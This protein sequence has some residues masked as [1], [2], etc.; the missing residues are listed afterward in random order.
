[1]R[2]YWDYESA[3]HREAGALAPEPLELPYGQQAPTSPFRSRDYATRWRA[4]EG[5]YRVV[6]A[7]CPPIRFI[8]RYGLGLRCPGD[9]HLRRLAMPLLDRII[10]PAQA[11]FGLMEVRGTPWPDSDSGFVASW[12]A[13]SEFAKIQTGVVVY[14]PREFCLYQGPIPNH[15]LLDNQPLDVMAGIEYAN[16]SRLIAIAGAPHGVARLNII[17]RLPSDSLK[18]A[19]GALFAW[20]FLALKTKVELLRLESAALAQ[21]ND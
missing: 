21:P 6:P 7:D 2:L 8:S 10:D 12:I 1:M 20:A 9:V 16:P 5:G 13:G 17:V 11:A 14:F 18:L 15:L 4:I 19:R 3:A